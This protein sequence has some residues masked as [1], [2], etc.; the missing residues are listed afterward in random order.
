MSCITT[1]DSRYP[2]LLN[3]IYD[4]PRKLYCRG[5]L[6]LLERRKVAIVGS[7]RA[8]DYGMRTALRL[9]ELLGNAGIT[10]VS[11]MAYG[12]DIAAHQGAWDTEGGT[13]AVL[14]GAIDM[15]KSPSKRDIFRRICQRGLA[16]SEYPPGTPAAP[17][18]FPRR[19]RI[20]SG[21]SEAVII[22][23]GA[24][25]SGSLITAELA[26]EQGRTVFAV[27]GDID[28]MQSLGPNR[29]IADG[30]VP[31]ISAGDILSYLGLKRSA[32]TD[33]GRDE[34]EIYDLISSRGELTLEGIARA[35]GRDK[36]DIT[37]IV[38]VLEIKGLCTTAM[39][40]I[41]LV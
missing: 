18:A 7:R 33:L 41:F 20:I 14:G 22:V 28:R 11:G 30:A 24:F 1:G 23:E 3:S 12:I 36:K 21:M 35:T 5:D 32:G 10:V 16:L 8:S 2:G 38:S 4:P 6:S 15:E 25:N 37:G 19:N 26:G 31:V 34:K 9:A 29:L 40:R 39:G 27:P 13:I 17:Q